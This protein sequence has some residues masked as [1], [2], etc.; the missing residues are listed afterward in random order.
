[1]SLVWTV[2]MLT[3]PGLI[4]LPHQ[5]FL[6]PVLGFFVA[7]AVFGV[8]LYRACVPSSWVDT[9]RASLPALVGS[10]LRATAIHPLAAPVARKRAP[11]NSQDAACFC[12]RPLAGDCAFPT[13]CRSASI[14]SSSEA[15]RAG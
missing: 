3:A 7:K 5:S 6:I 9:L 11:T 14:G 2:G 15:L 10:R 13:H 12:G 8:V 4:A 1:M